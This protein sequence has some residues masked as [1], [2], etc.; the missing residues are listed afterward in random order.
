MTLAGMVRNNIIDISCKISG[1]LGGNGNVLSDGGV[2]GL[3]NVVGHNKVVSRNISPTS[4][5]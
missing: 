5:A 4:M 1:T 2:E 3:A